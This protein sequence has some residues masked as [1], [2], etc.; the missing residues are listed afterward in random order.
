MLLSNG[1]EAS[2]E[3]PQLVDTLL[4]SEMLLSGSRRYSSR[5][6][7]TLGRPGRPGAPAQLCTPSAGQLDIALLFSLHSQ[8][9]T[10]GETRN[11][12]AQRL[13]EAL[14]AVES[15]AKLY[16]SAVDTTLDD[17]DA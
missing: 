13:F 16:C 7:N 14:A 9:K 3:L 8:I 2:N 4:Y 11:M 10:L 1:R 17:R 6:T 15:S 12:S 5:G